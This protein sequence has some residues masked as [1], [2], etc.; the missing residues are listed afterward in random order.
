MTA[1]PQLFMVAT[2]SAELVRAFR[3]LDEIAAAPRAEH[4]PALRALRELFQRANM[5]SKAEHAEDL[6]RLVAK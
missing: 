6:A 2:H 4:L 3:Q 1:H 5:P